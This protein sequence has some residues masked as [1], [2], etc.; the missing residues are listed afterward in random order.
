MISVLTKPIEDIGID[1]IQALI[2]SQVREG[3]EIEFK[4]GLSTKK[5]SSDSWLERRRLSDGAK[6]TILKQVTAFANAYGGAL[7]LGI[8]ES[9][10]KPSV[11]EHVAPIPHSADLAERLKL[12]V[13]DG[14]EPQIPTVEATAVPME[15]DNGVVVVRVG[16]SR[17]APHRVR[18]TR[19]CAVRRDD[20]TEEMTMREIQDMTL[21]VARGMERLDRRF[22]DRA[23]RFEDEFRR[24]ANPAQAWGVRVTAL[25]VG[26]ELRIERVHDGVGLVQGFDEPWRRVVRHRGDAATHLGDWITP[27]H[28]RP[29]IRGARAEYDFDA[30]RRSEF[31][32]YREIHCDGLVEVGGLSCLIDSTGRLSFP[33]DWPLVM[34][35]NAV[36]QADCLRRQ[37][38]TP[39]TEYGVEMEVRVTAPGPV[40]IAGGAYWRWRPQ[41]EPGSA[42][43]PRY[44][45]GSPEEASQLL[46]LFNRDFLNH[47]GVGV[48]AESDT[49]VIDRWPQTAGRRT[50]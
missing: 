17:M 22:S 5:H 23:Q 32:A 38:G 50:S 15:D 6:D 49:F 39:T 10:T 24:L 12:V 48:D 35:A 1:D 43:F 28:W 8:R 41:F 21:N 47:L 11:A 19:V 7:V 27:L 40:Q 46:G 26:D 25:P 29:I 34:L 18:S 14:V 9:S 42:P 37:S 30:D 45:L 36:T 20:R 3:Q 31:H 16:A 4:E 44:V 33:P 13:R 2:D